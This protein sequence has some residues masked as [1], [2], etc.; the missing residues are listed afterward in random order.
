MNG[1]I[2]TNGATRSVHSAMLLLYLFRSE[3]DMHGASQTRKTSPFV[4][5]CAGG[6]LI[7]SGFRCLLCPFW[8]HGADWLL[9]EQ[10]RCLVLFTTSLFFFACWQNKSWTVTESHNGHCISF[11][12]KATQPPFDEVASLKPSMIVRFDSNNITRF[13]GCSATHAK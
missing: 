13:V 1:L 8:K 12:A 3:S 7:A 4:S 5:R 2:V 9:D 10:R 11:E 6:E